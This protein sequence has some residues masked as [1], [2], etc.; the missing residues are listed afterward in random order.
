MTRLTSYTKLLLIGHANKDPQRVLPL[1]SV[2]SAPL[3]AR[4]VRFTSAAL[5][6]LKTE[7]SIDVSLLMHFFL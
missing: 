1:V 3:E 6:H 4:A 7:V 5:K 2:T